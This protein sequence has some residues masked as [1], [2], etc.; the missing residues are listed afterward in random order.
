M[1]DRPARRGVKRTTRSTSRVSRQTARANL[2]ADDA[3]RLRAKG[4][5]YLEIANELGISKGK[6]YERVIA[7]VAEVP[8]EDLDVVRG[9]EL[10]RIDEAY[11]RMCELQDAWMPYA[12][13]TAMV[14]VRD[15]ETGETVGEEPM[16]VPSEK[17]ADVVLKAIDRKA[18]LFEARFKWSGAAAALAAAAPKDPALAGSVAEAD[19]F[20][21]QEVAKLN[22]LLA[23][24][25][26]GPSTMS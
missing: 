9:V 24:N 21:A 19:D 10:G 16:Q 15:P 6:A 26:Q 22:E 13:G 25:R 1:P 11:R 8:A 4:Y 20:L 23:A 3:L 2:T 18:K 17:A 12:L 14:P 5:T 7:R